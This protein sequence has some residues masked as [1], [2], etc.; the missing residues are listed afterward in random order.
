MLPVLAIGALG[1]T[2]AMSDAAP[3]AGAAPSHDAAALVAAVPALASFATVR[4]T[5]IRNKPSAS[6]DVADVLAALTWARDEADRGVT[7]L[8]LTHGTDT[9]EETAYLL[10]MLWD[11]DPPIVV[12]GAMRAFDQPGTDA[13]ANLLAAARVA[14]SAGSQQ[15]G[16][17]VVLNEEIHLAPRVTKASSTG[18]EAFESPG[19]GVAGRVV[20]GEV[21]Y[22]AP[23]PRRAEALPVP[24]GGPVDVALIE[25]PLADDGAAVRALAAAGFAGLVVDASG[26]GHVSAATAD[27][28]ESAIADGVAVVVASRTL[29]G[30]TG[31]VTYGYAGSEMDLIARG[32]VM[33]GELSGRKAR[34]LLHVLLQ[35]GLRGSRLSGV[36]AERGRI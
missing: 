11:R 23:A 1:G 14:L 21:R 35:V 4:A 10:D 6:I 27:A 28:L 2:I 3:G 15:R 22:S 20:E 13:A 19:F 8:V 9:L 7:G 36:F 17:L 32:A 16:A 12:T 30:G 34:L 29:R 31:R 26:M 25:A 24:G 18:P 33:A 5:S